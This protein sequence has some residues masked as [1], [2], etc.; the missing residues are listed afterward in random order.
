[1]VLAGHEPSGC[2]PGSR[3]A[4]GLEPGAAESRWRGG[5]G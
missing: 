1:M 2:A 3:P 5:D 4:G